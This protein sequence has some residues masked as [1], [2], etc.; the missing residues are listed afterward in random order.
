MMGFVLW[1]DASGHQAGSSAGSCQVGSGMQV[2]MC[3]ELSQTHLLF[4]P[5]PAKPT[6]ISEDH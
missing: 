3:G 2:F 5:S 1:A 6:G 4:L